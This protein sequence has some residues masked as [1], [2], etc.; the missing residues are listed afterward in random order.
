MTIKTWVA[1]QKG[2]PWISTIGAML[3]EIDELRVKV[4]ELEH[5]ER[6]YTA[7]IG[8]RSYQEVADDLKRLDDWEN[9][10]PVGWTW[11]FQDGDL[12]E[13]PMGTMQEIERE[14][15]GYDGEPE[16]LYTK[17]KETT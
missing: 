17:P 14:C 16:P 8:E 9:Q 2:D 7:I 15:V 11:R 10:E 1:R 13:T 3:E 5:N 4:A 12:L 6:A